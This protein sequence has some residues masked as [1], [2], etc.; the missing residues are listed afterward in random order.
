MVNEDLTAGG[1]L[2]RGRGAG[3][4]A[5]RPLLAAG[6]L[7]GEHPGL[8]LQLPRLALAKQGR[9]ITTQLTGQAAF[10]NEHHQGQD[11]DGGSY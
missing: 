1:I 6:L 3:V 2:L 5:V 11:R 10:V 4:G 7:L 9:V 8:V